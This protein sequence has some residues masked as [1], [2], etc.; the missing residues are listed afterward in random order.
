MRHRP[1]LAGAAALALVLSLAACGD[2]GD[3]DTADTTTT[4]AETSEDTATT[5]EATE[6]EAED[7]TEA[8]EP[9]TTTAEEGQL[10]GL[11]LTAEDLGEG[12]AEQPYETSTEPGLCGGANV[13][14]GHPYDAIVGR[15]LL[16][17]EQRIALQQELRTYADEETAAAA[18][19]AYEEALSCGAE[20]AQEGV[21]LGEVADVSAVVGAPAFVVNVTAAEQEVEGGAVTVQVGPV[22][23][24]YQFQGP[25]GAEEGLDAVALVT[26]NV[27]AIQTELG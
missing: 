25:I 26:A 13:D 5:T 14:E 21:E 9:A 24:I 22:L 12:F 17:E 10:A 15:V 6:P 18:Y 3:D 4:E 7:T 23:S 11:L 1:L 2:D 8:T 27:E 20:T 19:A 16:G